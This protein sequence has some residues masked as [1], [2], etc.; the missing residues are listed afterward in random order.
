MIFAGYSFVNISNGDY[1]YAETQNGFNTGAELKFIWYTQGKVDYYLFGRY[2][3]I[4]LNED[5]SFTLLEYYRKVQLTSFGFGI[6]IKPKERVKF[7][8]QKIKNQ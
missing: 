8:K 5:I 4:Y 1:D 6:K 7:Q 3:F 2:D